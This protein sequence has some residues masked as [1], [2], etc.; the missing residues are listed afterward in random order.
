MVS[1]LYTPAGGL[2]LTHVTWDD[3]QSELQKA[4]Q[5]KATFGEN[6]N[7]VNLSLGKVMLILQLLL[8]FKFLIV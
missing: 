8:F 3:I 2:F 5:T 4:L 6:K 7:A 1:N